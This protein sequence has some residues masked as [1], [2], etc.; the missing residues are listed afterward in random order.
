VVLEKARVGLRKPKLSFRSATETSATVVPLY[1]QFPDPLTCENVVSYGYFMCWWRS[2]QEMKRW[3]RSWEDDQECLDS[4]SRRKRARQ[5]KE[6]EVKNLGLAYQNYKRRQSSGRVDYT[7]QST[8]SHRPNLQE[9]PDAGMY[10][11]GSN[12]DVNDL[13][14]DH[15]EV[16]KV[17]QHVAQH[18][19]H[20][21]DTQQVLDWTVILDSDTVQVVIDLGTGKRDLEST[22]IEVDT[23]E[24]TI[25][26]VY[27]G[28]KKFYLKI[29]KHA[30]L[31]GRF[32]WFST[33]T[34][35][36]SSPSLDDESRWTPGG[37]A[38]ID[39]GSEVDSFA[40]KSLALWPDRKS[41]LHKRLEG[42]SP[43]QKRPYK[44]NWQP[45]KPR[46]LEQKIRHTKGPYRVGSSQ[47][48]R[49]RRF[50]DL[51]AG[52][53]EHICQRRLLET[54]MACTA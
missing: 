16:I 36:R 50:K 9:L 27:C 44:P 13:S 12:G 8:E 19:E 33:D 17:E 45:Q 10:Q 41:D 54:H 7:L 52:V 40:L 49:P 39:F 43:L 48:D 35:V 1:N 28:A 30:K 42:H 38:D 34:S 22:P 24:Q 2:E 3:S 51:S 21:L 11:D 53:A 23:V 20:L 32:I 5:A 18:V 46:K 25:D 29:G 4:I 37:I 26:C 47:L 31:L 6:L 14:E 15:S